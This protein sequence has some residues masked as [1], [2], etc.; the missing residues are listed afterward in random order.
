[1]MSKLIG[2]QLASAPGT[3]VNY[4]TMPMVVDGQR[5]GLGVSPLDYLVD[6]ASIQRLAH[7]FVQSAMPVVE[8][9]IAQKLYIVAGVSVV[10]YAGLVYLI[11]RKSG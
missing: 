1:M 10:A 5:R 4:V 3:H 9:K 11:L 2:Y 7:Q 8:A 6:D